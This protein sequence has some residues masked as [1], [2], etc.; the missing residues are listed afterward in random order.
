MLCFLVSVS[1]YICQAL[2]TASLFCTLADPFLLQ[3]LMSLPIHIS[4]KEVAG[5]GGKV[6]CAEDAPTSMIPSCFPAKGSCPLRKVPSAA[7]CR[8]GFVRGCW[9]DLRWD[10][11]I[12]N[13]SAGDPGALCSFPPSA[14][15]HL[16]SCL[17]GFLPQA[18]V[19]EPMPGCPGSV[20]R[21]KVERGKFK[22]RE[23]GG[24]N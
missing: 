21:P 13:A 10:G 2:S 11:G 5:R 18:S 16:P 23:R 24:K 20:W 7:W 17:L 3:E 4:L 19:S 14:V 9:V 15:T 22:R 12:G 1:I 8:A 6:C